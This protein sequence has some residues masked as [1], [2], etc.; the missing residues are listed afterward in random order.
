MSSP[1]FFP[2]SGL[3]IFL[4]FAS[5]AGS[6]ALATAPVTE[7]DHLALPA[8]SSV[9]SETGCIV[10]HTGLL[11]WWRGET[12]GSDAAGVNDGTL[13]NGAAISLGQVGQAFEFDGVD[14]SVEIPHDDT[15]GGA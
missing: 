13:L 9:L 15:H 5:L 10:R 14:D 1:R 12:G 2:L 4:G 11:G 3:A 7:V 8:I 6:P